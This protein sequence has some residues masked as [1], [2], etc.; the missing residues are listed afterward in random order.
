VAL[1][2]DHLNHLLLQRFW[3]LRFGTLDQQHAEIR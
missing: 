3:G 2:G 1:I